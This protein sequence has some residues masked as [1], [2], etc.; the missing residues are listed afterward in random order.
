MRGWVAGARHHRLVNTL[1]CY[2]EDIH[3]NRAIVSVLL[4]NG[5]PKNLAHMN[6]ILQLNPTTLMEFETKY[7]GEDGPQI[8][9]IENVNPICLTELSYLKLV[10]LKDESQSITVEVFNANQPGE[11][12]ASIPKNSP[13]WLY[14][15]RAQLADQRIL[16]NPSRVPIQIMLDVDQYNRLAEL[17]PE[18]RQDG[19]VLRDTMFGKIVSGAYIPDCPD[20]AYG[21]DAV[22]PAYSILSS[23]PELLAIFGDE[24]VGQKLEWHEAT[25]AFDIY[26]APYKDQN[27]E[28]IKQFLETYTSLL[29]RLPD[30]RVEAPLPRNPKPK[31][32]LSKNIRVA[33]PRHL[34]NLE[35]IRQNTED[36]ETYQQA[37]EVILLVCCEKVSP[38]QRKNLLENPEEEAYILPIHPVIRESISTPVPSCSGCFSI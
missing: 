24:F 21:S 8:I 30:G 4:D 28:E 34:R 6:K 26:G 18:I 13:N 33:Y 20:W 25:D 10:S 1:Q 5:S 31:G 19:L 9:G 29:T 15:Y 36:S 23:D 27:Q 3:G 12:Y 11:W 38:E 16:E 35:Y 22:Y 14:K 37:M 17:T 32:I 2:V 7:L